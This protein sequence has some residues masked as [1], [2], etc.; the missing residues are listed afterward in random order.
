VL[1]TTWAAPWDGLA[2]TLRWRYLGSADS[3]L[4]SPDK[5]LQGKPALPLTSHISSYNYLDLSAQ[6]ALGKNVTMQFGVNNITDK[7]PPIIDS[8]GGGYGSNCPTIT[9]NLSSCN[10]NTWPGTYDALGRY[11]FMHVTAQF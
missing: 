11:L 4:T 2:V 3:E 9:N 1:N 10:G 6:F 7:D 5:Q 8:G